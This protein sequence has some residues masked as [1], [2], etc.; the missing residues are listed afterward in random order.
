MSVPPPPPPPGDPFVDAPPVPEE[1]VSEQTRRALRRYR[2][3]DVVEEPKED[4]E[5]E[6]L[7]LS[8]LLR[9]LVEKKLSNAEE[10]EAKAVRTGARFVPRGNAAAGAGNPVESPGPFAQAPPSMKLKPR[11]AQGASTKDQWQQSN[12]GLGNWFWY[13]A[14]IVATA[15]VTYLLTHNAAPR[16]SAAHPTRAGAISAMA[17]LTPVWPESRIA[18]LDAALAADQDGNLKL[19]Y[20]LGLELKQRMPDSP[21]L[22]LYLATLLARTGHAN[23]AENDSVKL[24]DAFTP[25]LEA[26]AVNENLGFTYARKRELERAASAFADAASTDPFNPTS[27]EQWAEA[28]RR[29]GQLQQAIARFSEALTRL[30]LGVV[31]TLSQRDEIAYKIRLTQIEAGQDQ[32]VKAALDGHLNQPRPEGYWLL[33]AAA[34]ALQHGDMA[35]AG[36][37][38]RRAR[39]A[40]PAA[41]YAELTNDYFYHNFSGRKE[42]AGLLPADTPQVRQ[43]PFVPRMGYFIDP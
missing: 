20:S 35:A 16:E 41:S 28:L 12:V 1:T 9:R 15:A 30:P 4:A 19:A 37:A 43:A 2:K 31:E 29:E 39:E 38:L 24:L 11:T 7:L 40:L 36:D 22:D 14:L 5:S 13:P 8:S 21:G 18:E 17:R 27:F 34:Y 3:S 25:P 26:A 42:I 10:P 32:E 33:T 6:I 23:D